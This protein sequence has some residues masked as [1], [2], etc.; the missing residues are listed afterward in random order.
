MK[1][2]FK[3]LKDFKQVENEEYCDGYNRALEDLKQEAIKHI[4]DLDKNRT[5]KND[6]FNDA[7]IEWIKYFFNIK[8]KED[9]K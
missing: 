3:T 5:V 8:E 1:K 4:E 7:I 9:L 6:F 2:Q